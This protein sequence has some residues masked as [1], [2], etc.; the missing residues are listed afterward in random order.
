MTLVGNRSMVAAVLASVL[1]SLVVSAAPGAAEESPAE[2][3]AEP[4]A[5][6]P[7]AEPAADEPAAEPAADEPAA[8]P[9]ADE[10]AAEPAAEEQEANYAPGM[11][12]GEHGGWVAVNPDGKQIG[13]TIVCT[14]EVCG[15]T[16][17]GTYTELV[18]GTGTDIKYVLKFLQD[19]VETAQS[20]NGVGN[21][22]GHNRGTYDHST[23]TW[24]YSDGAGRIFEIPLAYP[25]A[26]KGGNRTVDVLVYDPVDDDSL[27]EEPTPVFG[28]TPEPGT[29]DEEAALLDLVRESLPAVND[30]A[31]ANDVVFTDAAS[32]RRTLIGAN[33]ASALAVGATPTGVQQAEKLTWLYTWAAVR[34]LPADDRSQMRTD[35]RTSVGETRAERRMRSQARELAL[36]DVAASLMLTPLAGSETLDQCAIALTYAQGRIARGACALPDGTVRND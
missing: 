27:V 22:A 24:T 30:V 2:A 23:G 34:A 13:G 6:E 9:A 31:E 33:I 16:G 11:A 36:L 21:V 15:D 1:V 18:H 25:G 8:E 7:T 28:T 3:A 35:L 20:P 17:P 5:D 12:P 26:D 32:D 4:A 10:P 14:P 19:P 29:E